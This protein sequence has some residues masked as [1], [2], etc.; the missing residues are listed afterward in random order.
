MVELLYTSYYSFT[1][2]NH[3]NLSFPFLVLVFLLRLLL[4]CITMACL[5]YISLVPH[6]YNCSTSNSALLF[7][8]LLYYPRS[9]SATA[10][11]SSTYVPSPPTITLQRGNEH[12]KR[13][14]LAGSNEISRKILVQIKIVKNTSK[15]IFSALKVERIIK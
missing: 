13:E 5:K 15:I 14:K 7:C 11:V 10:K 12:E 6:Q 2:F 1:I 4:K 9:H 8:C 3:T